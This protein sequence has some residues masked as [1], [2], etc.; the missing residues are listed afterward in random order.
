MCATAL[1]LSA[2][3]GCTKKP[4]AYETL[5]QLKSA[6]DEPVTSPEQNKQHSDLA[7][8]VSEEG[9][10]EGLSRTDVEA[11]L[12]KGDPCARHPLCRERGF[13]D[14]DWYYEVGTLSES[15]D[16]PYL[17]YRPALILG[18]NRF[19]KVERTFVLRVE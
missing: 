19:G 17:R 4:T 18:F 14:D 7:R 8:L 1:A 6:L 10:L 2:S 5:P 3:A 15:P 12:G 11:K 13:E 16:T 9:H